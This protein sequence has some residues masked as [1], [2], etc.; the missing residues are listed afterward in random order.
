METIT[1]QIVNRGFAGEP[2]HI[3]LQEVESLKIHEF[4]K[5][6]KTIDGQIVTE[7]TLNDNDMT[8]FCIQRILNNGHK[9]QISVNEND[10]VTLHF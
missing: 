7:E 2:E 3:C 5:I 6:K 9:I 8:P 10:E 1:A 4:S